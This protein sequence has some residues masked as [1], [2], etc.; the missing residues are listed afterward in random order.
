M[1]AADFIV[2]VHHHFMPPLLFDRLANLAGGMLD[3]GKA[4]TTTSILS[5]PRDTRE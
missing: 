5:Q 1:A 4:G 2:D 3:Y